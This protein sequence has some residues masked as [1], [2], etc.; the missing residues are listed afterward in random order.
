[1][2]TSA[3]AAPTRTLKRV[4]RCPTRVSM[5]AAMTPV[6][7]TPCPR[8]SLSSAREGQP[9]TRGPGSA[10]AEHAGEGALLGRGHGQAPDVLDVDPVLRVRAPIAV[11]RRLPLR[12]ILVA[13]GLVARPRD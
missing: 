13:L 12:G 4:R 5:S 7:V 9:S 10:G 1:M 8:R 2:P 6:I 11:V 3:A